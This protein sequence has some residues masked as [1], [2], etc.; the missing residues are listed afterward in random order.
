MQ[1][2]PSYK[3]SPSYLPYLHIQTNI[4]HFPPIHT[5]EN[6]TYKPSPRPLQDKKDKTREKNLYTQ[7][8][9]TPLLCST[10]SLITVQRTR[11]K[12]HTPITSH[13]HNTHNSIHAFT[14]SFKSFQQKT[15]R[16]YANNHPRITQY[17]YTPTHPTTPPHRIRGCP[18][19]SLILSTSFSPI[20]HISLYVCT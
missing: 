14:H 16:I 5:P 1:R 4:H 20:S 7:E 9:A 11:Q 8:K 12:H 15:N 2:N 19:A 17:M 18:S 3:P 13:H 6:K 10:Q